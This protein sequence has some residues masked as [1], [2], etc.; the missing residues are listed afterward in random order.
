VSGTD[1]G[2]IK[3]WR[4]ENLANT[5][6]D[7]SVHAVDSGP[8]YS[9]AWSPDG[10]RIVAGGSGSITLYDAG[11]LTILFQNENAHAGRVD[12]VAFSP[13]G[14][15]VAS[16]GRDGELKLWTFSAP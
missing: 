14:T 7:V 3:V 11:T 12:D 5:P 10:S 6:P 1:S 8:V 13:D 2:T 16:A 15:F 9:L 4:I